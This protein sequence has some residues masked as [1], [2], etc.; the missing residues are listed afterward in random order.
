MLSRCGTEQMQANRQTVRHSAV[1]VLCC[2]ALARGCYVNG[3]SG[4]GGGGGESYIVRHVLSQ[5]YFGRFLSRHPCFIFPGKGVYVRERRDF[6]RAYHLCFSVLRGDRR[7][8][9]GVAIVLC[10]F[11]YRARVVYFYLPP[12][13][14]YSLSPLSFH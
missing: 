6:F 12:V 1:G 7:G 4:L 3:I 10:A 8:G 5:A 9:G 2:A 14:L 13:T 11:T